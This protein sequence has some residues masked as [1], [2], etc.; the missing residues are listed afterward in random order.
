M[1]SL[2]ED[3]T[4]SSV[5]HHMNKRFA[6]GDP[7]TEMRAL[8]QRFGLF[9]EK[10]SLKDAFN[11]LNIAPDHPKERTR[12]FKFLDHDMRNYSPD[13]DGVN[14]HDRVVQAYN[15]NLGSPNPLPVHTKVHLMKDD[16]RV[17]VTRGKPVSHSP[18]EHIVI[19]VPIKPRQP[20]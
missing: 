11:L 3:S 17:L 8:H 15:D 19:S 2:I 13:I 4:T 10:T 7:V 1:G 9:S 14:G 12:W 20:R 16:P 5:L 18:V 6:A